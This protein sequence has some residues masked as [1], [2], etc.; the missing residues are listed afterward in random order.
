MK[1]KTIKILS[2]MLAML[3]FTACSSNIDESAD[4]PRFYNVT[5]TASMGDADTRALS[6]GTGNAIIASFAEN[7]EVVVVDADG[8]TIVGTLKA[9]SAGES[10]TLSGTLDAK[11]LEVNEVVKLRY[12]SATANY[13]GQVGTLAGIA[14]GQDYAEG[15]LTVST[16]SPLAFISNS[17]TLDAKQ[18]ITKFSFKD[19]STDAAV[20]V[21]TFGIAAVG[22]VQS[23]ATNGTETVGA[24]TGTLASASSDVYVALR[25][26]SSSQAYSFTVKDND[27]NWYTATKNAKLTNVKNYVA[28][29]KLTKWIDKDN[30]LSSSSVVGTIGLLN[31][32]PAIAIGDNKA[33]ALMNVG[34]LCPEAYGTYYTFANQASGLPS[35]WYVPTKAEFDVLI[36]NTEDRTN[37]WAT[38]NGVSG[39]LFTIKGN[40]LFLPAAGYIDNDLYDGDSNSLLLDVSTVGYYW[41]QTNYDED[42]AY[43]YRFSS[44]SNNT[45]GEYKVNA[46]TVR[47]FHALN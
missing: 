16:T 5:L 20:S 26:S 33:V 1:V 39:R 3:A 25:T 46:L 43:C 27:G 35:G 22:L 12:R 30:N 34:A 6:E 37:D 29:V 42:E 28:T 31:G 24:V 19:A 4:A 45:Y 13:D 23:I 21:K 36:T 15:T 18:S 9:Q 8:S 10:T 47:P 32:L 40:K 44:P 17:V 7:D 14:A 2:G 41:S 11:T 38:R